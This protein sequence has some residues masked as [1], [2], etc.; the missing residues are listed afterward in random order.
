MFPAVPRAF[1]LCSIAALLSVASCRSP[2]SRTPEPAESGSPFAAY[3]A[4][5]VIVTPTG[6]VRASDSL[7]WVAQL[8]GPQ[9]VARRLD[10]SVVAAVRAVAPR[11]ILPA[12]LQRAYERNRTY[13]PDPYQLAWEP[14]RSPRFI[15]GER[16]GEPLSSQLRTT[17]AL[18]ED[19]RYV[20]LPIELRF[21]RDGPAPSRTGRGVLRAA[22]VDARTTEAQWVA[23]LRG[24]TSSVATVA[25]AKVAGK[26]ADL[27]AAP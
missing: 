27:F 7:G 1:M 19:A 18:H 5:R 10:S 22:L 21:E 4:Q 9:A 11:W 17:I 16:Y 3:L 15:T 2:Q 12:E 8:G 23:D 13:A 25:L 24:D 26:L 20:L 6:H 14:V